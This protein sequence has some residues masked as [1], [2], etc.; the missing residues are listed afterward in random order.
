MNLAIDD[1]DAPL[2][3]ATNL[4]LVRN[5]LGFVQGIADLKQ[6]HGRDVVRM[7]A[8]GRA[9]ADAMVTTQPGLVL[10]V[11][12]ADC[13]PVLLAADEGVVGAVHAGRKGMF[14]GTVVATVE[15]MR[16]LGAGRI[17]AWLGPH[18]CGSCYEVPEELQ[19]EVGQ[20]VPAAVCRTRNDTTGLDLAA[21]ISAQLADC[22]VQVESVGECTKENNDF[23]SYRRDGN[24]AGRQGGLIWLVQ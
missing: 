15:Q 12:S 5:E 19:R 18:I 16:A 3:R 21:G 17:S 6:V 11:R 7:T 14:L 13:V 10:L 24:K 22:G 20:A 4:D 8:P 2:S 9:V 23:F 1:A